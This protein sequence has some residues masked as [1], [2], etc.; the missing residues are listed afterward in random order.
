MAKQMNVNGKLLAV[1]M[2]L[3][4]LL[5][6]C[7]GNNGTSPELTT[8]PASAPGA[9]NTP[10]ATAEPA[11]E[12]T[13][14]TITMFQD[15]KGG[16]SESNLN[17]I[18][19][20]EKETGIKVEFNIIPGEGVEV[21]KKMDISIST[22]DTTDI[23]YLTNP[24]LVDKYSS[25]GWLLELND[26]IAKD[27]YDA[28]AVFGGYLKE[29]DGNLYTLPNY[30]GKWAVYYNKKIFDDAGVPYPSGQWTWDEYI[31]TAKKLTDPS[32]GIY[33]SY[34]LDY[35]VYMNFTA[36]QK[37][38]SGYKEDGSSN[39]DDP[40]FAEA[41]QFFGDLGSVHKVQ[42]SWMEFKTK[43]LPWDGFMSGRYGMHVI[44]SW[45]TDMFIGQDTYPR[46]W[47]FGITHLPV[48]SDGKGNNN[49]ISPAGI[50][51]SKNS[52]HPEE[53]FQFV[54]YWAENYYRYL[55]SLPARVDLTDAEMTELFKGVV[56]KLDN[57]ITIED[58]QSVLFDP[59]MGVADEKIVGTAASEYSNIILQESE[60]FLIG[61]KSLEDTIAAIKK[62]ADQAIQDELKNN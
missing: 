26:L 52:K 18:R 10:N 5:A 51:I 50:G 9:S 13:P 7:G 29:Y 61:E 56:E 16:V 19:D 2:S 44:G 28:E 21:Y 60:L 41:L 54:K 3:T 20:F 37:N 25:G 62:R 33:G 39:Y 38:V 45:Y 27:N 30:A 43:K 31:E 4:M 12:K 42:P 8:D 32:K 34:M 49:L 1:T 59:N 58:L 22:G 14:V 15:A 46:D 17:L 57:E 11:A 40:A 53:A 55:S 35:D 6:A 23:I 47:K 48:T 36:R 24:L